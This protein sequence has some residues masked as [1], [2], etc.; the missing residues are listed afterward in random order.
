MTLG[1]FFQAV[2]N[3]PSSILFYF[4]AIPLIAVLCYLWGRDEGHKSP[5]KYIYSGLIYLV[6]IPGIFAITLSVYLFMFERKSIFD[7]DMYLQVLPLLSM[8]ATLWL[9]KLNVE[10]KHIP[11]FGRITA[12]LLI[13]LM[14]FTLL[15][16][17]EKTRI[18]AITFVPFQYVVFI[19]A[20]IFILIYFGSKR[21][22][23]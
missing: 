5:W 9:I 4:V 23:K 20:A 14:V 1:D 12:L 21:V 7:T 10:F 13:I 11:G 15:W 8:I 22:F 6:S 19:L 16:I 3:N 2:G 17:L 18:F